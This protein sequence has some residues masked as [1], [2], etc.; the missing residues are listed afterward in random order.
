M[1]LWPPSSHHHYNGT[2]F[3]SKRFKEFL[4]ELYI[5]H[6]FT[7]VA[8]QAEATNRIIL[9]GLKTRLTHAKSSW[10][11]DLYNIL[12]AYRTTSKTPTRETPFRLAFG[13][14]DVIP[15]DIG[16]H[17]LRTQHFKLENNQAQLIA[18][19]DFLDY[20]REQALIRT[21]AYQQKV[22]KYYN[23]KVKTK[24]F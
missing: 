6:R 14:K 5:E 18:N 7:S 12:W 9:H 1:P 24:A 4:K 16:L 8:H 10:V 13:T 2:Q 19:L 3:N 21:A 20:L 17:A 15:L 11:E 23:S 22:A